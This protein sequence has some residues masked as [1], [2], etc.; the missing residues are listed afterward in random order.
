MTIKFLGDGKEFDVGDTVRIESTV[1]TEPPFSDTESKADPASITITIFDYSD[2]KVV[3]SQ[4]MT[5]N[6]TGQYFYKWD[7]SGENK[8][9][10][11]VVVSSSLN[12]TSE[13][14][15]DYIRLTD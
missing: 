3:D 7:T 4:S 11:E 9:D 14:E 8:G 12:G 10:F 13:E 6:D 1:T 15:D 2:N 5:Q